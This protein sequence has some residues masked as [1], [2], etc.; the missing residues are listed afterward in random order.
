MNKDSLMQRPEKSVA[1]P[2]VGGG[3]INWFNERQ[4][5]GWP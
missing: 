1:W 3:F 5:G 4:L 2:L